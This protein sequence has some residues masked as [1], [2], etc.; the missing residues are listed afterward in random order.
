MKNKDDA[1]LLKDV[2][3]PEDVTVVT[4]KLSLV[5]SSR[6]H[7]LILSSIFNTPLI[8]LSRGTKIDNFMALFGEKACGSV[9]EF[10]LQ[11]LKE[12]CIRLLEKNEEFR[13]KSR[14]VMEEY[15]E[16]AAHSVGLLKEVLK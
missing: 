4:S 12:N 2:I 5:I 7:L 10:N 3:E 11:Y 1:R 14:S 15:R 9:D 16:K 8:G 13:E 6:L